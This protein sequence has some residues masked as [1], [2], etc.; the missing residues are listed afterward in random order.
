[1]ALRKQTLDKRGRA[2]PG[3]GTRARAVYDMLLLGFR[4]CHIAKH[5]GVSKQAVSTIV[6]RIRH[7]EAAV[8]YERRRKRSDVDARITPA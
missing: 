4:N 6:W 7:P 8:T 3:R 5:A 1:M 2:I